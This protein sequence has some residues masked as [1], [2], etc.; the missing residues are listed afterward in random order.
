MNDFR[1]KKNDES[2][3]G[4]LKRVLVPEYTKMK[5]FAKKKGRRKESVYRRSA[6]HPPS[7]CS[8]SKI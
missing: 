2:G 6:A 4:P 8:L 1:E 5:D 3:M 7:Y